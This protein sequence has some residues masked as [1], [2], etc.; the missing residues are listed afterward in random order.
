MGNGGSKTRK[1]RRTKGHREPKVK[2][3]RIF[4]F[5]PKAKQQIKKLKGM[6]DKQRQDMRQILDIQ[7]R[8]QRTA[9]EM[10]TLRF[11]DNPSLDIETLS[12]Q[13]S[14]MP[15]DLSTRQAQHS[16]DTSPVLRRTK[17]TRHNDANTDQRSPPQF[18]L[19][20]NLDLVNR[21][22]TEGETGPR[23]SSSV[24]QDEE[25]ARS[26]MKRTVQLNSQSDRLI[27]EDGK[28]SEFET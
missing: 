23:L 25:H 20:D 4:V 8:L 1:N 16:T 3:S 15:A 6:N 10:N 26:P 27:F 11:T 21:I 17:R 9:A 28:F 24:T 12:Q 13:L 19:Q 5:N 22:N 7:D 2:S 18:P 14:Q